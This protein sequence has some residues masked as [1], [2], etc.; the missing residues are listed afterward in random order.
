VKSPTIQALVALVLVTTAVMCPAQVINEIATRADKRTA[1]ER[2]DEAVAAGKDSLAVALYETWLSAV[3]NDTAAASLLSRAYARAGRNAESLKALSITAEPKPPTDQRVQTIYTLQV[4]MGSYKVLMPK[5]V[6][7][8]T[9]Y[10]VVL[11]LH[12]NGHTEEL[13]LEWVKQLGMDS[14]V[15]VLPRAPYPRVEEIIATHRPRFSASDVAPGFPDSLMTAV[16]EASAAW[17]HDALTDASARFPISNVKPI[18][19][20][21]SQGGFYSYAVATRYPQTFQSVVSIS[22]S[23]YFYGGVQSHFADLRAYGID[24]LVLHGRQDP[25]V[26]FQVGELIASLLTRSQVDHTFVPFDGAH[27]PTTEATKQIRSWL[28]YHLK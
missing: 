14:V 20:G 17:Y 16:V 13:M 25:I 19:V 27:W 10:P 24:A 8:G 28:Y 7:P 4:R 22:A 21:F 11:V 5:L 2:A 12:G 1:R 3:P 6:K 15:F 26:P 9:K 18:V 23:M